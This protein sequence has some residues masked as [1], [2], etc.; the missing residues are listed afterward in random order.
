MTLYTSK[1]IA[2]WLFFEAQLVAH[3]VVH[4]PV[5]DVPLYCVRGFVL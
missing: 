3:L 2:Q 1:V 5:L 4:F